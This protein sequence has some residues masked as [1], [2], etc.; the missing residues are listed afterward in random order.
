MK[1]ER[2]HELQTN[3]LAHFV[4]QGIEKTRGHW[5]TIGWAAVALLAVIVAVSFLSTR[6]AGSQAEA[7]QKYYEAQSVDPSLVVNRLKRIAESYP[8]T[9]V[10][11][12][13]R[14]DLADQLAS[15]GH[16]KLDSDRDAG[17]TRLKEARE[18]YSAVLENPRARP[19]MIRRAAIAEGK[20]FEL[21]GERE[22]AIASYK[23]AAKKFASSLPS[24]AKEAE[25]LAT[26]LEKPEAADFYKWLAEYKPPAS[27]ADGPDFNFGFPPATNGK[28][29]EPAS[30]EPPEKKESES[31]TADKPS[32]DKKPN[33][34]DTAKKPA[35]G[36]ATEKDDAAEQ[37]KSDTQPPKKDPESEKKELD[38]AKGDS[39]KPTPKKPDDSPPPEKKDQP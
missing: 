39:E 3:T 16:G 15:D 31:P 22:K 30:D 27:P 37:K 32:D 38:P 1:A 17:V 8:D 20:C 2:R 18:T 6:Q 12:W 24:V 35:T 28:E 26:E 21:I 7:W 9:D 33:D 4:N 19:D 36:E 14:L 25:R 13:A 5:G 23:A 10:A 29:K 11:I 34:T